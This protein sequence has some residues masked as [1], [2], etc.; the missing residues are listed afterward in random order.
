MKPEAIEQAIGVDS[1]TRLRASK[2]KQIRDANAY[3]AAR[4]VPQPGDFDYEPPPRSKS[5]KRTST[6][7]R[8]MKLA[9]PRAFFV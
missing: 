4:R 8:W 5:K 9:R 2:R 6:S 7:T 1:L 3:A